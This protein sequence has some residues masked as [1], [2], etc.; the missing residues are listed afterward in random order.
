[1]D[2]DGRCTFVAHDDCDTCNGRDD[3]EQGNVRLSGL[4][5]VGAAETVT[6]YVRLLLSMATDYLMSRGPTQQA[7]IQSLRTI[8]DHMEAILNNAPHT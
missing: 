6:N 8:A 1:M 5:G 3:S 2:C 7:F 4:L